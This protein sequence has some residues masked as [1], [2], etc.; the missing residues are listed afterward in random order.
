MFR[1]AGWPNEDSHAY[2]IT[3]SA[4]VRDLEALCPENIPFLHLQPPL[5]ERFRHEQHKDG[6]Y[7]ISQEITPPIHPSEV[8]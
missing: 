6:S 2:G 8:H 4:S 5:K 1:Q 3:S 7:L